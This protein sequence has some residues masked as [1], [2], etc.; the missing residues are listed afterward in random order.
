MPLCDYVVGY[1]LVLFVFVVWLFTCSVVISTRDLLTWVQFMN[2]SLPT[3]T[4]VQAFCH[5]AHLVFLDALGCG[6]HASSLGLREGLL[7]CIRDKLGSCCQPEEWEEL[8]TAG[9]FVMT[10]STCGIQPFMISKGNRVI[11]GRSAPPPLPPPRK[12]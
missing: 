8:S 1:L 2:S 10:E 6:A 3:L 11:C 7:S 4:P 9:E 5:G 12:S